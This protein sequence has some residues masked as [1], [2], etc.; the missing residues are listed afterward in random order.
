MGST[1]GNISRPARPQLSASKEAL[2]RQRVQGGLKTVNHVSQIPA[3]AS[4]PTAP[5]SFTQQRLWFLQQLEIDSP[6][7]NVA[8]ALRLTGPLDFNA[9]EHAIRQIHDRHAVLRATF[10][11]PDGTPL[12]TI[13]ATTDVRCELVDLQHL[14][15]EEKERT[16]AAVVHERGHK[17]FDLIHGP[18]TRYTLIRHTPDE[19]IFVMVMHHI[20]TDGWSVTLFLRE[21]EALYDNLTRSVPADL[22]A[23]PIQYSDFSFWQHETLRGDALQNETKYWKDKLAGA[24]AAIDLPTDHDERPDAIVRGATRSIQL[25]PQFDRAL[26]AASHAHNATE[27]MMLIAA[28]AFTLNR[29]T[30]QS[31]LVLGT[32]AAGRTRREIENLVGCFMNFLPLRV[33]VA[34]D[35]TASQ[36]LAAIK[37]TVLEAQAHQDC[38]FEK[39][40]EA[41]NPARGIHRNPLYNVA[42]LL[43]NF[44]SGVLSNSRLSAQF[45]RVPI[46]ASLLDLRFVVEQNDRGL[47]IGC[48]YDT[49]L[50]DPS[51]ID[52][53]LEAFQA[54]LSKLVEASATPVAD[55]I[56]PAPLTVQ[57][58]AALARR[59]LQTIAI[60]ATF[61]AD[62]VQDSLLYWLQELEMAA[63]VACAP[64]NQLFQQLLDASSLLNENRAGLNVLLIRVEDWSTNNGTQIS[65]TIPEFLAALKAAATRTAVPWLVCFPPVSCTQASDH[66]TALI[67][68]LRNMPGVFVLTAAEI[69]HW[70]PVANIFDAAADRLGNVPYTP[71]FFAAL[72]TAIARKFHALKRPPRKVIA[73]DCDNTLWDGVC[74]EDGPRGIRVDA[75]RR[76]LQEFMRRQ[77][78]AGMLL[79]LCTKN[80]E[81]DIADV[82]QCRSDFP[83]RRTDFVASR[84]NW[85]SK[86]ENLK[87]LARE[88]NV[89]LDS[90]IF[91]DDNPMECA[92][93][94][95]NCPG[96]LALQLPEDPSSIPTFLEHA[97]IFDHLKTTAED[98][99]R[100]KLYQENQQREQLRGQCV[101]M[102]DFLAG[103]NLNINIEPAHPE[104]FARL[105]QLTQRTNQFN[106]TTRRYSEAEIQQLGATPRTKLFA[107]S[108]ND[109][110]GD[111]GLVGA[112]I[113]RLTNDSVDIDTFLLSCRVL[114]KGVE[115]RMLAHLGELAKANNLHRVDLHFRSTPKNRPALDFL[116][117]IAAA[118]RQNDRDGSV[119]RLPARIA[120]AIHYEPRELEDLSPSDNAADKVVAPSELPR[121]FTKCRAIALRS[122]DGQSILEAIEAWRHANHTA[123]QSSVPYA[124]P[125]TH[126]ERELCAIWAALLKVDQVGIHDDFFALRGSSLLAVRLFS[127]IEKTLGKAL[128]LV[129]LFQ[130]PTIEK[131]AHAIDQ[132]KAH[133]TTS[134][135]VPIQAD[136]SRPPLV[137]VHGAGGGILWGYANLAAHL[138]SD[139]PV[140]AIEPR[141]AAAARESLSVEQ[142]AQAYLADLRAFQPRGPY[143]IGGYCF[144]GYVAYEMARLLEQANERVAL[145]ALIDSAAPNG[146]YERIPW[147]EPIFYLRWACNTCFWLADFISVGPREQWQFIKRKFVVYARRG[148]RRRAKDKHAI[149]VREYIETTYFPEEELRLW[150]VHLEAGET[151]QPRPYGGRVTLLRTRGQPILCSFDPEY[152]WGELAR[153]GVETRIIRGAH[154]GIFVEPDIRSLAAEMAACIRQAGSA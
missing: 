79:C 32:V 9:F 107:V 99:N 35:T 117:K 144:G 85:K 122:H 138:G 128:P 80:N 91:V 60:S 26:V 150:K 74:G 61:T 111:Y 145:L 16:A 1:T 106:C 75:R 88:L 55:F 17:P 33:K 3:R 20:V 54:T 96:V 36:L 24:P 86:S 153:G 15:G 148:F 31:D 108:V 47:W 10:P 5:L 39:I 81:A 45:M 77:T 89:R 109:R 48:E 78:N 6:A 18:V 135:I 59:E 90:F 123:V 64:Y 137:L 134:S 29:W 44:P 119:F 113:A 12:Q 68:Q 152:G 57:A 97:W 19:H 71:Q 105:S 103:L 118:F 100:T 23:L 21:L 139:Q 34:A 51:T 112:I 92:E 65:Q 11:A 133:S 149:D 67:S 95:A 115:H 58:T 104:Q 72:G 120:A 146:N 8:T 102:A 76:A 84:V 63:K 129:T 125:R 70:Y 116:E 4:T 124:A 22:P 142:M 127:Q 136:G 41:I 98:R 126:T 131:L 49:A 154:E 66:A 40:V 87:S 69:Q 93:V 141:L 94:E 37:G 30:G 140:Y 42:L 82:F 53:L 83:L 38:P 101:T 132:R 130:A 28:L 2:L 114:G 56:L 143:Y 14:V 25:S 46:N 43:Q 50:F 147:T 151:Y 73:L 110:F 62:P 52:S 7:Y 13:T 121:R 27:F